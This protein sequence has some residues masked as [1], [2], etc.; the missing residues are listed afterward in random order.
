MAPD[1]ERA[2]ERPT[3]ARVSARRRAFSASGVR[4]GDHIL[5]PRTGLAIRGRAGAWVAVAREDG[6]SAAAVADALSTAFM[7]QPVDEIDALCRQSPGLEVW[8]VREPTGA[9]DGPDL[10]HLGAPGT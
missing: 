3:L 10:V 2:R 9:G 4:K 7:I 8:L 6:A 5:D 1:P